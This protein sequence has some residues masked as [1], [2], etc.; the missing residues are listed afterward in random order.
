[1]KVSE[2]SVKHPVIITMLLIVLIAFGFFSLG[3]MRTEFMEDISMPQAIVYTVYPGAS[4]EDVENDITK[5][6]EDSF[7]TLPHFKAIDSTSSNSL[8][9]I[10]ITYADG[11]D[12][13]DQ[14]PELRN[15]ISEL[16]EKL[17]DGISG[18]PRALVGGMSM[19]PIISFSA[20]SGQDTARLT[21]YLQDELT[22]LLTQ[23]DGVSQPS[24]CLKVRKPFP[25]IILSWE[26]CTCL[27]VPG[28]IR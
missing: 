12:P 13:Y 24:I 7:V 1:M 20:S 27:A 8:S 15:R 9:W 19:V 10:L 21:Q 2:F 28:P 6:L 25:P 22:P 14:L 17:P 3:G 11:Y 26:V 16:V 4:A 18:E 5:V 23:I